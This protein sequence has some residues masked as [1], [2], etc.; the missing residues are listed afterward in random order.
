M[1]L[2]AHIWAAIHLVKGLLWE[3]LIVGLHRILLI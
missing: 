3:S 2:Q 1:V